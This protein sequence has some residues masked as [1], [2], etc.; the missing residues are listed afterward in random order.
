MLLVEASE[1]ELSTGLERF[2]QPGLKRVL[3]SSDRQQREM[4]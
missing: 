2:V 3:S 4:R 1:E